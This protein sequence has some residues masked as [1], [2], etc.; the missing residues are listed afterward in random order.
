MDRFMDDIEVGAKHTINTYLF[1]YLLT[2]NGFKS[3]LKEE[4][5]YFHAFARDLSSI[6]EHS[7]TA[8]RILER[9][10]IRTSSLLVEI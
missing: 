4:R 1:T 10:G 9:L 2:H 5:S 3:I 7:H 8:K 6:F